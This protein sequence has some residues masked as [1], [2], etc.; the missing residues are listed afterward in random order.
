L[1]IAVEKTSEVICYS[2]TTCW[3]NWIIGQNICVCQSLYR[4]WNR[5]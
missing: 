4:D 1:E 3:N 5:M 2:A